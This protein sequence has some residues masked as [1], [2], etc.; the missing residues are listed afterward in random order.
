VV[1]GHGIDTALFT[2]GGERRDQHLL[3]TVGRITLSKR[4][5]VILQTIG[6]LPLA[7]HLTVAGAPITSADQDFQN[8]LHG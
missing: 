6:G 4:L 8:V 5:D 1:V 3:A 2:M 7:Y